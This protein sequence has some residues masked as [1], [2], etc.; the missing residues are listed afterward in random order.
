MP[1]NPLLEVVRY[2]LPADNLIELLETILPTANHRGLRQ[3]GCLSPLLLNLYLHHHLDRPWQQK[4]PRLPLIRVADDLLILCKTECQAVEAYD[5]LRASAFAPRDALEGVPPRIGR[6]LWQWR[7]R[8]LVGLQNLQAQP[9][10]CLHD[11]QPRLEELAGAPRNLAHTKSDA[12][13]RAVQTIKLWLSQKGPAYK[14]SDRE[15][16]AQWITERTHALGFQEIP[17]SKKLIEFW[18]RAY[19]RWAKLAPFNA[20]CH[21][22]IPRLAH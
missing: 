14:A 21:G 9:R 17:S 4:C 7:L 22:K 1:I 18:Q 12:P 10:A 2:Y 6:E 15:K 16:V 19:A 3:G 20:R 13:L 11:G 8:D 5:E